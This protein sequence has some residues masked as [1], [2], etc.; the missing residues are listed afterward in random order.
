MVLTGKN[1]FL[2]ILEGKDYLWFWLF[3][4]LSGNSYVIVYESQRN[5][6]KSASQTKWLR[7]QSRTFVIMLR[8][9]LLF[10]FRP[11]APIYIFSS[12]LLTSFFLNLNLYRVIEECCMGM[13][14]VNYWCSATKTSRHRQFTIHCPAS[15]LRIETRTCLAIRVLFVYMHHQQHPSIYKRMSPPFKSTWW[16]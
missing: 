6:I 14:C 8:R 10:E 16:I 15:C 7:P 3:K 12:L 4:F 5:F 13:I 1:V 2:I 9:H 11:K